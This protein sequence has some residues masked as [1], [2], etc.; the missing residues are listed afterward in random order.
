M[1]VAEGVGRR[2]LRTFARVPS[3]LN[4]LGTLFLSLAALNGGSIS[5]HVGKKNAIGIRK[6]SIRTFF[7]E[8]K[9]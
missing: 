9:S 1:P 8:T 3:G 6:A 2:Q 5:C 4:P 7:Q